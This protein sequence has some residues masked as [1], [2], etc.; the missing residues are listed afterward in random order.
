MACHD[1][2]R[3]FLTGVLVAKIVFNV[4]CHSS[5][6]CSKYINVL[7]GKRLLDSAPVRRF[8]PNGC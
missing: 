3:K 8:F 1:L 4:K 5:Q 6:Q 7:V 2:V